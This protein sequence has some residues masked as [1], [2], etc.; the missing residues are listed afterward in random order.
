MSRFFIDRPIFAIVVALLL[1]IIGAIAGFSLPIAQYP[2]ISPPTVSVQTTYT[3][4]SGKV[5]ND[6]VAQ[7]IEQQVNGT[8]GMDYMSST[9][10]DSGAYTLNVYFELGTNGDMDSVLVQNNVSIATS[11]LPSEVTAY[12][13]TTKKSSQDMTLVGA[14]SSPNGSFDRNF[15]KN[16]LDIY[17]IDQVKR[18]HGVG[19]VNVFATNYTMRVWLNPDKI[20][21][22]GITISD[23]VN[24]IRDQNVQAPGGTVGMMPA[25]DTQERQYT[26]IVQGRLETPEDFQRVIVK[27]GENGSFV[28]LGDIAR[29]APGQLQIATETSTNG[30]ASVGF[31]V[32]LTD[33]A[34]ALETVREV[35]KVI[36][37]AKKDFP[38][39][40]AYTEI[41]DNTKFI[42]ASLAEVV[43]TFVEALLIVLVVVF[44]FLQ[45]WR[46]TLIPMLAVPVSMVAT[47][48]S[49][50][51]FGF[52]INTLTLF[53]MV[54]F[55]FYHQYADA[56][57]D[58]A[59]HRPRR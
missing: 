21:E 31:A 1:V 58:G 57:R 53:A 2:Q 40:M 52:T 35:K 30:E 26:G 48:I 17:L 55:W 9:S 46:A 18:V 28:R 41:V 20:A 25:P 11:S 27:A 36:E 13:V 32:M 6:T 10:D 37:S 54:L 44:V 24:A 19:D 56:F 4:A 59:C 16:Y 15:I 51:P 43:E 23:V 5:V 38:P 39:D 22:L 14:V 45:N 50:V 49:F 12:G 33:D 29:I 47:F 34:N 3:G 42:T 8:Q 7:V